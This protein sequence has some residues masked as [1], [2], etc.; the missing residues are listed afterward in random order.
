MWARRAELCGLAS[1]PHDIIDGM[2]GELCLL[3]G[4]EQPRRVV[5]MGAIEKEHAHAIRTII[6]VRVPREPSSIQR[7]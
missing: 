4:H 5:S 1:D 2:A 3:L 7:G 6:A